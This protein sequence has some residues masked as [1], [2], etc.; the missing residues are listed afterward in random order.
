MTDKRDKESCRQQRQGRRQTTE[1]GKVADN[2]DRQGGRQM[3]TATETGKE[4]DSDRQWEG[5]RQQQRHGER[6]THADSNIFRQTN[7]E[8]GRDSRHRERKSPVKLTG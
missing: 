5:D 6:Q 8:V 3:R 1:T 2:R 7:T 4:T